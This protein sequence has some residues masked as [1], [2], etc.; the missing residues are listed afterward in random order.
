MPIEASSIAPELVLDPVRLADAARAALH[1][2]AVGLARARHLQRDVPGAVPVPA[3][4]L[5]HLAVDA[6][7]ARDHEADV[8]LLE[9]VGGAVANA[10]SG[11]AYA[12]RVKPNACS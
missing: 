3:R 4:E 7:P 8:A 1:R 12:V 9:H 2:L 6:Q 11:P 5:R 10:V